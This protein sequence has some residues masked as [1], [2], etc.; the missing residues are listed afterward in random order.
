MARKSSKA[1]AAKTTGGPPKLTPMMEQFH[2]AKQAH[3][4]AVL[5]FRMG[6]FYELFHDDAERI[7]PL[8]GLTLTSR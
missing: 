1:T 4:D 2:A 7:A 5:F 8:L 6:D 3:P